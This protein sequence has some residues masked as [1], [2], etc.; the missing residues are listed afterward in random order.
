MYVEAQAG[1]VRGISEL[2]KGSVRFYW[3]WAI[4]IASWQQHV[5]K[6]R[7]RWMLERRL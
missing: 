6:G 7:L 4:A 3:G 5:W 1:K 2:G